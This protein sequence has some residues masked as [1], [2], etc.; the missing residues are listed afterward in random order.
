V[1]RP[2][3]VLVVEQLRRPVP[4]GIGTYVSGLLGGVA[5][6]PEGV[7]PSLLLH[8]SAPRRP[9]DPLSRFG[10]PVSTSPLPAPLLVRAW[11]HGLCRLSAGDL[12]H[13][14]S[15]AAPRPGP[16]LVV[17]V[18]DVA[19]RDEPAAG[20]R[21]RR[22]HEAALRRAARWS[23]HFVVPSQATAD[24]LLDSGHGIVADRVSVIEEGADHLPSPDPAAAG[25]LLARL[26]VS[27]P[28][29]L[30]VGTLEPR[31]N[32]ARLFEAYSLAR[33]RLPEPWPL[34]VAG[35]PGW[36]AAT[37]PP[38]GVLLT[39]WMPA[40]VL[41]ALY[42]GARSVLYVPL[43]EGF[44]L[45]VAEAMA[46]GTPVVCSAVPSAGGATLV[47]DPLVPDDIAAG[48]V[49]AATDEER[50]AQLR[51]AGLARA[52]GLTWRRAAEQHVS[53]WRRLIAA[54]P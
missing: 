7:A 54:G 1:T 16:P 17:T 43:H 27:G 11:D 40:A 52:A 13:A 26:G 3:V 33:P 23:R 30:A 32:L 8:A 53:L 5:Q 12:V 10:V 44:G 22:W 21:R 35:P 36:G 20:G 42:R 47:V 51:A 31:K 45:P 18:H 34:L 41:A 39:G 9:P 28:F 29:L 4:G 14:C 48:I 38:D 15:L 37:R 50:R 49:A 46:A 6:L 24:A 19:W 2:E 25:E